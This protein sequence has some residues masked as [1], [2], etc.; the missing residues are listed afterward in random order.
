M[1]W[2]PMDLMTHTGDTEK[3]IADQVN[4]LFKKQHLLASKNDWVN[5]YCNKKK[6]VEKRGISAYLFKWLARCC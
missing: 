1:C 6:A 5:Y 4:C 2:F 3:Y